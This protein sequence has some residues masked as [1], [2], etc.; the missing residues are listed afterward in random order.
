VSWGAYVD[1]SMRQRPNA[2]GVYVI[3]AAVLQTDEADDTRDA[4]VKLGHGKRPFHWRLSE[5]AD[6][7]RAVELV[8]ALGTMQVVVVATKLDNKRQERGRRYCLERLL[9]ELD[10]LGVER[11]WL[12]ARSPHLNRR[13]LALVDALRSRGVL[14]SGLRI[15]FCQFFNGIN[16]E[17]L[18]WIPDIV[19]GAVSAA[20][21]DGVH[22]F[23]V[24]LRE[25]LVEVQIELQ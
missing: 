22:R 12:D 19:A 17:I 7:D 16:G 20:H 9:W 6:Q 1:E 25:V 5:P 18:L 21:G 13:D 15:D 4:L 10:Q 2:E 8:A 23:V 3:A 24:P 14:R 11:V